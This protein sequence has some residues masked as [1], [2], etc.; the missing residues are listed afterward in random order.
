MEVMVEDW[1]KNW[2]SNA[3]SAGNYPGGSAPCT[4]SKKKACNIL[5]EK[6]YKW[7]H[8]QLIFGCCNEISESVTELSSTGVQD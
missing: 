8:L 1:I 5:K 2:R 4:L 7:H 3:T 6:I